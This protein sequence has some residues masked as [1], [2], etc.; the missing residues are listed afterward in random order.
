MERYAEVAPLNDLSQLRRFL[1]DADPQ[2]VKFVLI[3]LIKL[4][5]A[6]VA[7]TGTVPPIEFYLEALP[8]YL[9]GGEVPVDLVMEE[10]QLRR[11]SGET[12]PQEEYKNRFPQFDS[13]L[14]QLVGVAEAT[15][16]VK[17]RAA[18]PELEIG[19]QIDDFLIVQTLGSGAFAHVYLARQVSMARLVALSSRLI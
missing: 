6:M 16:A 11:E 3:E 18:P 5:M 17:N 8:E 9:P 4:D 15:S 19:S 2:T 13:V 1:P 7:E 10:V 12:P 14:V